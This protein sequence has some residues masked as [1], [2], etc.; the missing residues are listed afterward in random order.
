MPYARRENMKIEKR[1]QNDEKQ[2]EIIYILNENILT[3]RNDWCKDTI[4]FVEMKVKKEYFN[5]YD[6]A[7]QS[8]I[9]KISHW[10]DSCFCFSTNKT[11]KRK[12][13]RRKFQSLQR[14]CK[15]KLNNKEEKQIIK[16]IVDCLPRKVFPSHS[17]L[18]YDSYCQ[19]FVIYNIK[20]IQLEKNCMCQKK[21]CI[22][23][24]RINK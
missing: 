7:F 11:N 8:N 19:P 4:D 18:Y 21:R 9:I 10:W 13:K 5:S 16:Q 1:F 14:K 17:D 22:T 24:I 20:Q 6:E 23:G 2:F 15:L 3:S 12:R